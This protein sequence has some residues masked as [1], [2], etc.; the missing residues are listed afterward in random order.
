MLCFGYGDTDLRPADFRVH[1]V[2]STSIRPGMRSLLS[3]LRG[4]HPDLPSNP[5]EWDQMLALAEEHHLLPW[6]ARHCLR[7]PSLSPEVSRRLKTIEREAAIAA[8]YWSSELQGLLRAAEQR[9]L[10]IVPLKG[11]HL[12]ER[13]YG[14]A[15][16][17]TSYDLDLLVAKRDLPEAAALLS[18]LGFRPGPADD[19]HQPW[20]RG[21]TTVELHQDVANPLAF[22]FHIEEALRRTV[23]CEFQGQRCWRLAAD[24]ELLFLCLHAAR[25]RFERLS[26]VL[27]LGFA[28]EKLPHVERAR[29]S[30]QLRERDG[31]L[32]LAFAMAE[33]LRP[34]SHLLP[35]PIA[36]PKHLVHLDK[37]ADRLWTE[38]LTT[39]AETLDWRDLHAFYLEMEPPGLRLQ[40]RWRHLRILLQRVIEPDYA[41]AARFGLRREWQV[42]LLRPLRLITAAGGRDGRS[43]E[44]GTQTDSLRPGG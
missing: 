4:A 12:A 2:E 9:D 16:L 37:L 25:H 14:D 13:L 32:T 18:A 29:E 43:E 22:D 15:A 5:V 38:L 19:Y 39:Q 30:P 17:R 44:A 42:R 10:R 20:F 1:S 41:F 36:S 11:P 7:A 24:D 40:R 35:P 34:E 28:F 3:I 23:A 27:D 33:R 31:L 6:V 8:F 26:L 21:A